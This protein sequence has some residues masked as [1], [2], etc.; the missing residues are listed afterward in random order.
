MQLPRATRPYLK[1]R[2][3]WCYLYRAI[4]RDVNLI[5][6]MLSCGV[7]RHHF[8]LRSAMSTV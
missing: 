3:R 5:D 7:Y 1:V 2:G 4:D 6:A 8:N